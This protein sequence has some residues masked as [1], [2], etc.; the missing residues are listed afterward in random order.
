MNL[1]NRSNVLTESKKA[2]LKAAGVSDADLAALEALAAENQ[3]LGPCDE[4]RPLYGGNSG[5]RHLGD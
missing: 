3:S 2:E 1:Q 5:G 4:A